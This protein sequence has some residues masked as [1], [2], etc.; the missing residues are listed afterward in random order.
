MPACVRVALTLLILSASLLPTSSAQARSDDPWIH[1]TVVDREA[2]GSTVEINLPLAMIG[3]ALAMAPDSAL[4]NGHLH[5][6]ANGVSLADIRKLWSQLRAAGDAQFVKVSKPDAEVSL[7][8]E[9]DLLKIRVDATAP[10]SE[11][12]RMQLPVALVDALFAG[13][14]DRIDLA[15]A[16]QRLESTRGEVITVDDSDSHVRIWIDEQASSGR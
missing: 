5:I 9:G 12:V 13:E 11:T 14:G 3:T 4:A 15:A 10:R 8:R 16:L 2:G 6:D 1:I 7:A